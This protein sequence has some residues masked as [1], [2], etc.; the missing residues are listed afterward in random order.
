MLVF[1]IIGAI[2]NI[3]FLIFWIYHIITTIKQT[4]RCRVLIYLRMIKSIMKGFL[5]AVFIAIFLTF[6]VEIIM[7][8]TFF[9][10]DLYTSF[11]SF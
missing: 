5:F 7:N 8:G 4:I 9:G 2:S 11:H 1:M 3:Q 6:S 10:K